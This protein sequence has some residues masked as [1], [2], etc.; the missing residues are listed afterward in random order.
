[1]GKPKS[2]KSNSK[3]HMK[4]T[5]NVLEDMNELARKYRGKLNLS[6]T[7]IKTINKKEGTSTN[8]EINS[9]LALWEM[10]LAQ[11]CVL[12]PV[13][14]V[15][16]FVDDEGPP[17]DF[18][19]VRNN[20][21]NE[22]AKQLLDPMFLV[23]CECFPRCSQNKCTC[24]QN[25]HGKFAYDRK[26][27]IL[28]P[29]GSPIYEC[30]AKC[31][32]SSDCPNRVIQKGL[33]VRV[34]IFRTENGRG[35]GLKAREFIPAGKFV[36]EYVGEIITSEEAERR[37]KYYDSRQQTYLFDLDFHDKDALFTID[38]YKY[39]NVS[40][41]INHSCDPNLHVFSVWVD[42]LDPRLPRIGLFAKRDIQVSEELTF[43]Y[44]M[45]SGYSDS[46]L[47]SPNKFN[48]LSISPNIGRA[49]CACG[50]KKC[51]KYLF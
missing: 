2:L 32:C 28:L 46:S 12:D 49:Y 43:D 51:R 47:M 8:P 10:E 20:I 19:Y 15:E 16:N 40:H 17:E 48:N 31:K 23:G 42:T 30:N 9:K 24:P 21:T 29:A 11:I 38:A 26:K 27:N 34:C 3:L 37:G 45:T 39:G 22:L 41:F 4:C 44:M 14:A 7:S 13:I 50:S 18:I 36:V 35:W 33:T 25:S 5:V 1:M 6:M